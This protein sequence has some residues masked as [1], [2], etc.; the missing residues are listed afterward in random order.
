M[1]TN[2]CTLCRP[3][4]FSG[5]FPRAGQQQAA[6]GGGGG[7]MQLQAQQP[8]RAARTFEDLAGARQSRQV[9]GDLLPGGN[10][11]PDALPLHPDA[12]NHPSAAAAG[13]G[14]DRQLPASCT[15]EPWDIAI[16]AVCALCRQAGACDAASQR[17]AATLRAPHHAPRPHPRSAPAA[18]VDWSL[19]TTARFSS[20]MP[21]G[22]AEEA[23]F[24]PA[25]A[26]VAAQRACASCEAG[27]HTLSMQQRFLA[28]LHSWQFPQNPGAGPA[29]GAG[30]AA[31]LRGPPPE[32]LARRRDWQA[33]FCSLYDAMRSGA[34]DAFYYLAPEVTSR[35]ERV[36]RRRRMGSLAPAG[37][38]SARRPG[39]QHRRHARGQG[40]QYS[41]NA[42]Q[43]LLPQHAAPPPTPAGQ[44]EALCRVLWCGGRGRPAA[45]ARA[46]DPLYGGPACAAERRA[47]RGLCGAAAAR[48]CRPACGAGPGGGAV[49]AGGCGHVHLGAAGAA[50]SDC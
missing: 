6:L 27:L 11:L 34:C 50:G 43:L 45:P 20:P 4:D 44:Q 49:K 22:I 1:I 30:G 16:V 21:F 2:V 46:A 18:P 39:L 14:A 41:S 35:G 10:W 25:G 8:A 23:G 33:A 5:L 36:S 32:A 9:L 15:G 19:K 13:G 29:G 47:G 38:D 7:G 3:T 48:G 26:V 37:A 24:L 17:P 28:A 12:T 42:P 40:L 31:K